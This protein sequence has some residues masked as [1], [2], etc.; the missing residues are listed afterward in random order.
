MTNKLYLRS[1]KCYTKDLERTQLQIKSELLSW[2]HKTN[3]IRKTNEV[4][5]ISR[6]TVNTSSMGEGRP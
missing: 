5:L 2:V 3:G 1:T 6:T 4:I